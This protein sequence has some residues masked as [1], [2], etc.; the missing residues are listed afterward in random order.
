M[1]YDESMEEERE[2][3]QEEKGWRRKRVYREAKERNESGKLNPRDVESSAF[4]QVTKKKVEEKVYEGS[5]GGFSTYITECAA[6][7]QSG[8]KSQW[9][10]RESKFMHKTI[11]MYCMLYKKYI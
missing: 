3:K 2:T 10:Q 6:L 9:T 4:V 5:M 8:G 7:L 11:Y 1:V